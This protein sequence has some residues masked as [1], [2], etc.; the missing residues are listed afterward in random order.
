MQKVFEI[1]FW[2][3]QRHMEFQI[4][5][6]T[7]F[8]KGSLL[9][10]SKEPF[11]V[12]FSHKNVHEDCLGIKNC[13]KPNAS[14]RPPKD[15]WHFLNTTLGSYFQALVFVRTRFTGFLTHNHHLMVGLRSLSCSKTPF[16]SFFTQFTQVRD[17]PMDP[18]G[19]RHYCL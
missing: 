7:E 15:Y 19:Y 2:R 18:P 16:Q 4:D 5:S 1:S 11:A 13:F 6:R 8:G 9:K 3:K 14:E 12:H 10:S 17:A